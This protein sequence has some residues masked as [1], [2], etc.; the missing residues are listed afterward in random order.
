MSNLFESITGLVSSKL[1]S[2][3]LLAKVFQLE[4]RLAA[5]GVLPL[6]IHTVMFLIISMTLWLLVMSLVAYGL[7]YLL[8]SI[9][10]ALLLV[11]VIN[12]GIM[13]TIYR[14]ALSNIRKMSFEK[15]REYFS[16][17]PED[18]HDEAE[19]TNLPRADADR[20]AVKA[21]VE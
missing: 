10:L 13:Y 7:F 1:E 18:I 6:I 5:M 8:G 12:L 21:R 17:H 19:T 16:H 2:Y 4:T 15:T 14:L 3:K 20:H 11:V 9:A